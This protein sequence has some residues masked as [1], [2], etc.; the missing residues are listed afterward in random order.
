MHRLDNRLSTSRKEIANYIRTIYNDNMTQLITFRK[1]RKKK[2]KKTER[3]KYGRGSGYLDTY[4][5][6]KVQMYNM[7]LALRISFYGLYIRNSRLTHR[8]VIDLTNMNSI[9]KPQSKIC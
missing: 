5:V 8:R 6:V 9:V 4:R 7:T 1:I 2:K 3:K